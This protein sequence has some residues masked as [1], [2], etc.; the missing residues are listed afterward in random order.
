MTESTTK[1]VR[2]YGLNDY[3]TY[4]N[5]EEA[6]NLLE[7][8]DFAQTSYTVTEILES[9]NATLYVDNKLFHKDRSAHDIEGLKSLANKAKKVIAVYFNSLTK[10]NVG[11]I[12]EVPYVIFRNYWTCSGHIKYMKK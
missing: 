8:F 2:Y 5:L 4:F 7:E 3:A 11:N 1:L 6:M 10:E 12:I 9:Y